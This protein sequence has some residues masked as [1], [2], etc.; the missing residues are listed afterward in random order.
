[1]IFGGGFGKVAS[2][3]RSA[4]HVSGWDTPCTDSRPTTARYLAVADPPRLSLGAFTIVLRRQNAIS[5]GA[6]CRLPVS[7]ICT[8]WPIASP[9]HSFAQPRRPVLIYSALDSSLVKNV[10]TSIVTTTCY[11]HVSRSTLTAVERSQLLARS[12]WPDGLELTPTFYPGIQRAAQTVLGVFLN[13][14]AV[15]FVLPVF[16]SLDDVI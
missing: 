2:L 10:N 3:R 4:A 9:S 11:S 13:C 6:P 8:S 16:R 5:P 12:R 7:A 15:R 14:V 1:M